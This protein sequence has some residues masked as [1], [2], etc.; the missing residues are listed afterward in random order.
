MN[1]NEGRTNRDPFRWRSAL[2]LT[3]VAL[4]VL[5]VL[6][7]FGIAGGVLLGLLLYATNLLLILEIGRSLLRAGEPSRPKVAAALSSSGR[8]LFLA[9]A[10]SLMATFLGRE[11]VLGACGGFLIAQVNLHVPRLERKREGR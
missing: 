11:V 9:M 3:V 4:I 6:G 7:E 10:L 8:L 5:A 1:S 2:L